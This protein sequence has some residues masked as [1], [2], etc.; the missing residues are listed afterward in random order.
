LI[1]FPF[2]PGARIEATQLNKAHRLWI[3][4]WLAEIEEGIEQFEVSSSICLAGLIAETW[5]YGRPK[6]DWIGI[7]REYLEKDDLPLAY[8]EEYGKRLFKFNQW[9]QSPVHAIY[10]RWWIERT[11]EAEERDW[12]QTIKNYIQPS[13]WIYNP[14]VSLTNTKTRMRTELFMSMQMGCEILKTYE[15]EGIPTDRL[16][17]ATISIPCTGY[18]SAEYFRYRALQFLGAT[19]QMVT[20]IEKTLN[21]L[22]IQQGFADFSVEDKIDDYMGSKKRITRDVAV[23]SPIATLYALSLACNLSVPKDLI[24][25]WKSRVKTHLNNDPLG[26]PALHMRDLAPEFGDGQTIYEVLAAAVLLQT[27]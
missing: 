20:G 5:I 27:H 16:V 14:D 2:L 13:G 12:A 9:K 25:E 11:I 1:E 10:A 4:K 19:E 21:K 18:V 17:A 26:I 3:L 23:F 15:F 22:Q 7:M 8:S 24:E 6:T